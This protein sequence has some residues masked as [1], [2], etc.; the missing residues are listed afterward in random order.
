MRIKE[1]S[2][3]GLF[4]S[5]GTCG[6]STHA[7]FTGIADVIR[8]TGTT[9]DQP[10]QVEVDD[11]GEPGTSDTFGIQTTGY[12]NGPSVLIGGNIQIHQ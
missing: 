3:T 10:F 12:S 11:C 7:E 4:I 8:S 6:P 5:D 9:P 2:Y 1:T